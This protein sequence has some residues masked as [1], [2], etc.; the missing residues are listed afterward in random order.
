VRDEKIL[1][2]GPTGVVALPVAQA[3]SA[4]N[5]VWGAARFTDQAAKAQLEE[6]G[7]HCV[8]ID[9]VDGDLSALPDDFT[10][11]LNFAVLKTDEWGRDL[12]GNA[13]GVAFLMEHCQGAK[14]FLHCSSTAV[15]QANGH[16][17]FTEDDPLGDNHRVLE[18]LFGSG[19]TYSI[20]K[21]AAE[22][23]ARYG[24]RRWK[25]PTTIVRLN[26]PYGA[27]GGLPAINLD[28]MVAG[29]P[30]P[31]HPDAPSRYNPIHEDDIMA[32]IPGLMAAASVP[33]TIVN[34]GGEP[35][36]IEEWC[37][38]L[39]E[40]T[41]LEPAF[42]STDQWIESV[43]VDLTRMHDLVGPTKVDLK[44]G[45]GRMVQARHPELL[46]RRLP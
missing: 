25:L 11:I 5:E 30:V 26:V 4:D 29:M 6:A 17:A 2:T 1:V 35:A 18:K 27:N 16:H 23:V 12:D 41:G 14:A 10:Y 28:M 20:S 36:T 24:A 8:A 38:Y 21:I 15:Y 7:V 31:V 19:Q 13:G 9:L 42:R 44:D 46:K 45:L 39:G 40:L 3:L 34:W 22:A 33:A 37:T 43:T 32:T